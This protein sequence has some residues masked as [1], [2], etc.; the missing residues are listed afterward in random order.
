MPSVLSGSDQRD[1]GNRD[2]DRSGDAG[3]IYGGAAEQRVAEAERVVGYAREL[4]SAVDQAARYLAEEVAHRSTSSGS[5][6]QQPLLATEGQWSAWREVYGGLLNV[7]SGPL[8]DQ[9]YGRQEAQL[10]YQNGWLYRNQ[11]Q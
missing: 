5:V 3:P 10:E 6:G 7:L 2:P 1:V 9:G 4:W 11:S 8:G